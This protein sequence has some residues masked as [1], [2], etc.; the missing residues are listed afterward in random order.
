[1]ACAEG[2]DSWLPAR[3]AGLRFCLQRALLACQ[4]PAAVARQRAAQRLH[5]P[6]RASRSGRIRSTFQPLYTQRRFAS[7]VDMPRG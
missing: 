2:T 1:M 7:K 3:A 6:K 4:G 5:G